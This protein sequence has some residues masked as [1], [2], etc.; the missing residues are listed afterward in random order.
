M[1]VAAAT[2]TRLSSL[3]AL[4][5]V[6]ILFHLV[7]V[8]TR[9]IHFESVLT[10]GAIFKVGFITVSALMHWAIYSGL[11]FTFALTLRPG[12]EA[13]ISAMARKLHGPI[14]GELVI[15]TRRVTIAWCCFFATQLVTSITLFLFAPLV[16]WSFFVNVLDIPLVLA[17]YSAEY[18]WRL[19]CLQNPPRHS[20]T[21]ILDM[22]SEVRKLREGPASSS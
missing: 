6:P 8:E 20:L 17:M 21:M 5:A 15:Y 13:L 18:L 4:G 2:R 12:R 22:V 9:H 10:C 19:R 16:V 7:I 11:L 3:I 1:H 14:S